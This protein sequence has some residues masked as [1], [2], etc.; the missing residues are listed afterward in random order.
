MHGEALPPIWVEVD[1][2]C[3]N[4]IIR[5]VSGA[6][7]FDRWLVIAACRRWAGKLP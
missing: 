1:G 4:V 6:P 3:C 7:A 2:P 5:T